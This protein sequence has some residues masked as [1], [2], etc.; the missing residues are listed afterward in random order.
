MT[1]LSIGI[2]GDHA[3]HLFFVTKWLL[4]IPTPCLLAFWLVAGLTLVFLR[5]DLA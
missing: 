1:Y 2:T 5:A 3:M 4:A